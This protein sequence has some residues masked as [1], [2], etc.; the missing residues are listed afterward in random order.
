MA[1]D[2]LFV[3]LIEWQWILFV[4]ELGSEVF[5]HWIEIENGYWKAGMHGG[6]QLKMFDVMWVQEEDTFF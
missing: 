5:G 1:M 4:L 6:F 3:F 2:T